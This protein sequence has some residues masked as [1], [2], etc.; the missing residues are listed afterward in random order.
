MIRSEKTVLS[1]Q[2]IEAFAAQALECTQQMHRLACQEDWQALTVLE[3]ER[4]QI[5]TALF[6][7]PALPQMLA[8]IADTL[9]QI[10]EMD[11]KTMALGK[12]AQQALRREMELLNQGKRAVDAYL[13]NIA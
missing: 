7:H 9:R 4:S 1:I 13:G 3:N 2:T 8:R 11:Q 6:D 5:L 10:I 12:Q